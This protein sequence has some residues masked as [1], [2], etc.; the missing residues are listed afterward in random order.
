MTYEKL[1]ELVMKGR[2][3]NATAK[4]LGIPQKTFEGYVKQRSFPNCSSTIVLANEAGVELGEAVK[5]VSKKELEVKTKS[6]YVAAALDKLAVSFNA[7]LS[8]AKAA[9]SKDLA[10]T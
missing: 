9:K 4:A 6:Q 1:I 5:A 10:A 3:V 7:L 2:S 8:I